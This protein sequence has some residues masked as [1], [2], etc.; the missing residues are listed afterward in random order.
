VEAT[1]QSILGVLEK[2]CLVFVNHYIKRMYN[3]RSHDHHIYD[4]SCPICFPSR[5][6]RSPLAS[7]GISRETLRIVLPLLFR[8]SISWQYGTWVKLR[9]KRAHKLQRPHAPPRPRPRPR[10]SSLPRTDCISV[11][12]FEYYQNFP[13]LI[14]HQAANQLIATQANGLTR[15]S[16]PS[17]PNALMPRALFPKCN[18]IFAEVHTRR[19]S[20]MSC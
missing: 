10:S 12:L 6:F 20:K 14:A 16:T 1:V 17:S 7:L 3:T 15:A 4:P 8:T 18:K 2:D 9:T 11:P 19:W 13:P 5:H